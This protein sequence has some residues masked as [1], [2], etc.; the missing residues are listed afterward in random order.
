VFFIIE[1]S[2]RRIVQV[3]VTRSPTDA[4]VAQRLREATPFGEGPRFLICDND[5]MYGQE[6]AHVAAGPGIR[7]L[8]TPIAAP[9]ANAICERLL[10]NI[11]RECLDHVIILCEQHLRQLATKYVTF[12]NHAR[13]HQ[14]LNQRTPV[15]DSSEHPV[16]AG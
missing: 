4:W 12:Y 6:S 9:K 11:R 1:H 16:R 14:G 3:G 13:P 8:H 7:L 2:S 10:G 15:V 5:D